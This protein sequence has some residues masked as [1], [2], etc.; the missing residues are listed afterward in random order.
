MLSNNTNDS[1]A[2]QM[3]VMLDLQEK[4]NRK[5]NPDW[6]QANYAWYRAAWIECAELLDH[7]GWKWWKKQR[8][9]LAQVKLELIDIWHFGL[10]MHLV[11]NPDSEQTPERL[12]QTLIEE[13]QVSSQSANHSDDF[14]ALLEAFTQPLLTDKRFSLSHF[15]ALLHFL[16]MDFRALFVGY[17]GKN[18]LNFFRQDK[19]YKEGTYIKIW[20]GK[21]DNEHLV[22]ILASI[23]PDSETFKDDV[24]KALDE[25]YRS[26][27]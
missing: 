13:W 11:A 27:N 25:R 22:D 9:D 12:A 17:V 5:V 10:S 16:K 18:V 23:T 24:Y 4:M 7:Y 1:M 14:G 2:S 20:S 15:V 3:R 26:L 21:E 19:G 6:R 8:P